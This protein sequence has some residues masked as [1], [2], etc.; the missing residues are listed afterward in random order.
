MLG[1]MGHP[2]DS[3]GR[4][5]LVNTVKQKTIHKKRGKKAIN[6]T[7]MCGSGT[8]TDTGQNTQKLRKIKHN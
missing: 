3:A 5:M 7:F 2:D 4:E 1:G 6:R 8:I